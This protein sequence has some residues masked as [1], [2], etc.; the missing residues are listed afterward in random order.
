MIGI[1]LSV[2]LKSALELRHSKVSERNE[3]VPIK[4]VLLRSEGWK[5]SMITQALRIHESTITRHINDF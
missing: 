5:I 1:K 2:T 3:R 4:A